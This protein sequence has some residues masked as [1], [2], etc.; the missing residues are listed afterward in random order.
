MTYNLA[1]FNGTGNNVFDNNTNKEF[2]A[3]AIITPPVN[4]HNFLRGLTV[5]ASYATSKKLQTA[6]ST[7]QKSA[8]KTV[9]IRTQSTGKDSVITYTT[10]PA[11]SGTAI[12]TVQGT[13]ERFGVDISYIRTPVNLTFEGVIG[14]EVGTSA[15]NKATDSVPDFT[16]AKKKYAGGSITLFF[17]FGGQFLKGYREQ[18]RPDDWWP[19]T[20]QPFFRVDAYDPD[21][22][23]DNVTYKADG[24]TIDKDG[25][26]QAIGT[27]GANLF[28]ARTTKLQINLRGRKL[29]GGDLNY[30][31]ALIQFSYGF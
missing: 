29:Q 23:L 3:R 13:R 30:Y 8:A 19:F 10:S 14:S 12:D 1:L 7:Y 26:W 31:D 15:V 25:R 9:K 20:W 22:D 28:F 17:N 16:H 21:L 4:Y 2:V 6:T 18:S 24:K 27:V 5:G 11:V